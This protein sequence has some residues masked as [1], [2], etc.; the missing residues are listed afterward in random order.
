M[1]DQIFQDY[2]DKVID[3]DEKLVEVYGTYTNT[4]IKWIQCEDITVRNLVNRICD[5]F[6]SSGYDLNDVSIEE[7]RD[8]FIDTRVKV[9]TPSQYIGLTEAKRYTEEKLAN[10]H[11][12]EAFK[13]HPEREMV[14]KN[15]KNALEA[16]IS[17]IKELM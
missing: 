7:I 14:E 11:S 5:D 4:P 1:L 9:E 17:K 3:G 13:D 12:N 2:W 10:F 8:I 16:I 15:L 6:E